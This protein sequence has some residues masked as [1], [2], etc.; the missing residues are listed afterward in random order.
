MAT[1]QLTRYMDPSLYLH[2]MKQEIRS[3]IRE[4]SAGE[5]HL[6]VIESKG[7]P[8]KLVLRDNRI[9]TVAMDA[10]RLIIERFR[11]THG[12]GTYVEEFYDCD[13]FTDVFVG[14]VKL[15]FG[16]SCRLNGIANVT[17]W[18]GAHA[19]VMVYLVKDDGLDVGWIEPQTG[20]IMDVSPG[21][22]PYAMDDGFILS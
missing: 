11:R 3:G 15:V 22:G 16:R 2:N 6:A 4:Y 19:Y 10:W 8:L 1:A 14:W 17:D 13:D 18:S 12:L 7:S 9:R 20:R 5:A 21:E